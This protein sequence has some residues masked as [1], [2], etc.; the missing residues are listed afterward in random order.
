[1]RVFGRS[2]SEEGLV[3]SPLSFSDPQLLV[4]AAFMFKR[5]SELWREEESLGS[6]RGEKDLRSRNN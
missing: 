3:M 6:R 4:L 5:K 2:I 1:M